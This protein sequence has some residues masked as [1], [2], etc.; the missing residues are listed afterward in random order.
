MTTERAELSCIIVTIC[1]KSVEVSDPGIMA[2]LFTFYKE[3]IHIVFQFHFTLRNP[4]WR[5]KFPIM[6]DMVHIDCHIVILL[7]L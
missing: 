5:Y 7:K 2:E 6:F 4:Q 1:K 3:K